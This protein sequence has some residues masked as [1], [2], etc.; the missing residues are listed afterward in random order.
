MKHGADFEK[1][2]VEGVKEV[3][4]LESASL[5]IHIITEK[6]LQGRKKATTWQVFAELSKTCFLIT[7]CLH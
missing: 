7:E 3:A 4:E 1:R 5:I 6:V 2:D